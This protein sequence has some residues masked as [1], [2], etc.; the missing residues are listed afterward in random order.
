[1]K[2]ELYEEQPIYKN[3]FTNL[4]N[5]MRMKKISPDLYVLNFVSC[6]EELYKFMNFIFTMR[7][8][9]INIK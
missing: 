6:M 9:S 3:K 4:I 1:M 7:M 8:K 2:L 5:A